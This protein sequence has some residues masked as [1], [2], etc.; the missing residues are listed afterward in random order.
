MPLP[1]LP[2][3]GLLHSFILAGAAATLVVTLALAWL[4]SGFLER[5]L[6]QRDG[7]TSAD[8][9]QSVI[10]TQGVAP[11]FQGEGQVP[12]AE[13]VEFLAHLSALPEVLRINVYRLDKQVLWSSRPEMIGRRFGPNEEL[14]AALAGA[15]VVHR[16]TDGPDPQLKSEHMLMDARADEFIENYLPVRAAGGQAVIGVIELYR[17]PLALVA[18]LDSGRR[19]VALSALGGGLF[20]FLC[21]VW[22]M[23]RA[24]AALR[25]QQRKLVEAETLVRIGELS[26]AVAHS[27]RNPLGSIRSS[28]ELHRELGDAPEAL[29]GELIQHVDRIETLV[30]TLLGYAQQRGARLTGADLG[31]VLREV[32]PRIEAAARAQGKPFELTLAPG[33]HPVEADPELLAQLLDS[34]L[35]NALEATTAGQAI[36]LRLHADAGDFVVEVEDEGPGVPPDQLDRIFEP[37]FTTKP[38]GL[39]MGL[40]LARRAAERLGGALRAGPR[41][42]RG[43][44]MELRL[45]RSAG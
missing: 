36:R 37:F 42:G 9:L 2:T 30:R 17:R 6:L 28:A 1:R 3:L 44:R 25:L 21:L 39:G 4:L 32:T 13:V 24:D 15:V 34:L 11:W 22:F 27:I 35:S 29:T 18:A 45:P 26:G 7:L 20:I 23:R 14:D 5:Q 38:R 10:D 41:A 8:L 33:P 43:L 31:R 12:A 40:A 16:D 19:L